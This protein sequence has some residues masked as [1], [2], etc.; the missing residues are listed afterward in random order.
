MV[1]AVRPVSVLITNVL[2]ISVAVWCWLLA[3]GPLRRPRLC[4]P[5]VCRCPWSRWPRRGAWSL[6][7]RR[8]RPSP[9]PRGWGWTLPSVWATERGASSYYRD[10]IVTV[11][12]RKVETQEMLEILRWKYPGAEVSRGV[13]GTGSVPPVLPLCTL[14]TKTDV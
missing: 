12:R 3:L 5:P 6:S 11:C 14:N 2:L 9:R 4:P 8:M 13:H 10:K 1:A 7:M